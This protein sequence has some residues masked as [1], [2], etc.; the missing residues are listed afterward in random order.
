MENDFE[1]RA[2]AI[3]AQKL[4]NLLESKGASAFAVANM[5]EN[6]WNAATQIA[7]VN[8]PSQTTKD[9]VIAILRSREALASVFPR[10][11]SVR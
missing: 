6:G 3:K 5:D 4:A 7:N 9:L 1:E 11:M 10:K 2:R 8:P